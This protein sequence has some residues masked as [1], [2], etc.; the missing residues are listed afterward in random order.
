[1]WVKDH[2]E[3]ITVPHRPQKQTKQNISDNHWDPRSELYHKQN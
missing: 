2:D 3:E 1:M